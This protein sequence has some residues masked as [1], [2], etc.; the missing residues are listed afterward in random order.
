[1]SVLHSFRRN[2]CPLR[3][4]SRV[5]CCSTLYLVNLLQMLYTIVSRAPSAKAQRVTYLDTL[6]E[7]DVT[8]H[9][10]TEDCRT[11]ALLHIWSPSPWPCHVHKW[12]ALAPI[13][14]HIHLCHAAPLQ[15]RAARH[16]R[17]RAHEFW[18][19]VGLRVWGFRIWGLWF[20]VQ[21]AC[22]VAV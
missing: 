3:Q 9:V 20:R 14:R 2:K 22:I 8:Q 11:A 7:D 1:M 21:V 6:F 17:V 18:E 15:L 4:L 12:Q 16:L 10:P 5:R 13:C 19:C